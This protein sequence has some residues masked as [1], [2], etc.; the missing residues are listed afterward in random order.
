MYTPHVF[1]SLQL[2]EI[3]NQQVQILLAYIHLLHFRRSTRPPQGQIY[4][5][6]ADK[7]AKAQEFAGSG[8]TTAP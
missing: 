6:I 5:G 2:P 3:A 4:K 8:V 7:F 1:N